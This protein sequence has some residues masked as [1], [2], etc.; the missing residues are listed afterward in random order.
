MEVA[1]GSWT[2]EFYGRKTALS[3]AKLFKAKGPKFTEAVDNA[4]MWKYIV[5][6]CS[7]RKLTNMQ[8]RDI[9]V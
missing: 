2:K 1:W 4:H 3:Y 8:A 7:K 5:K 6:L 9:T